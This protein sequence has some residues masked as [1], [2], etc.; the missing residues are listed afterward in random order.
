MNVDWMSF[1]VIWLALM[2]LAILIVSIAQ[3]I[4]QLRGKMRTWEAP[5]PRRYGLGC[6]C[7]CGAPSQD[8]EVHGNEVTCMGCGE[9]P[10][11]DVGYIEDTEL[12]YEEMAREW[13]DSGPD[14]ALGHIDD[15]YAEPMDLFDPD[16]D[17]QCEI[18]GRQMGPNDVFC[19]AC[20]AED[21]DL[22]LRGYEPDGDPDEWPYEEERHGD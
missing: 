14:P 15:P 20:D 3:T 18:H 2:F 17:A 5:A 13:P 22:A 19:E 10:Y 11:V 8:W 6:C 9:D 1:V 4:K 12:W 21:Y 7:N 16:R